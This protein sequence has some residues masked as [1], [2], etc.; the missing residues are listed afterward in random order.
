MQHERQ[1]GALFK[2][3]IHINFYSIYTHY[4]KTVQIRRGF[5]IEKQY[6]FKCLF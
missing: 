3:Y 6:E 1:H 2:L 5:L 4:I